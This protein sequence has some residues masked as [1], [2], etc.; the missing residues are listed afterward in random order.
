MRSYKTMLSK[1]NQINIKSSSN[2]SS[3]NDILITKNLAQKSL[4]S[5]WNK[6]KVSNYNLLISPCPFCLEIQEKEEGCSQCKIP[7]IICSDDGYKGLIG[8]IFIKYGNELLKNIGNREY[9]LVRES[10]LN[11]SKNGIISLNIVKKIKILL[12]LEGFIS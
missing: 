5:K 8:Y 7:E 12:N 1:N 3:N 11:L 2:K 4:E 6:K 9:N 10:L